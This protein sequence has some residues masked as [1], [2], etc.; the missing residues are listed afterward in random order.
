MERNTEEHGRNGRRIGHSGKCIAAHL[1]LLVVIPIVNNYKA[2][3]K[4]A[5]EVK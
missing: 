5:A 4:S 2:Q 3:I 1:E